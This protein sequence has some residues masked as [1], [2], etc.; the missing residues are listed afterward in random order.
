MNVRSAS[1]TLWL[2]ARRARAR[3]RGRRAG[4]RTL[5]SSRAAGGAGA[6]RRRAPP[7][8]SSGSRAC[9]IASRT[10]RWRSARATASPGTT[11]ASMMG[12]HWFQP[13]LL[14]DSVCDLERP[15]FLQYLMIEGQ[16]TLI[17]VG[18]V[19]DATQPTPTGSARKPSGTVT[20]PSSAASAAA[21]ST[22]RATTRR[23]LPNPLNDDTWEDICALWWAEPERREIVMLH[24]W[25]W[26]AHPDG[27]FVH[28]NRAIPFLRAGLRVPSRAELDTPEGR[29]ALDTLRLAHGDVTRR[30]EGAFLVADLGRF[31]AWSA[32]RVLRH[33]ERRGEEAVERM[34]AAEKLGDPRAVGRG[35]PRR[36]RRARGHAE[37]NRRRAR[38]RHPRG[39]RALPRLRSS[40]TSITRTIQPRQ[41]TSSAGVSAGCP[42]AQ[43]G[44]GADR[45]PTRAAGGRPTRRATGSRSGRRARSRR[46]SR[47]AASRNRARARETG[48]RRRGSER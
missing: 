46:G 27:P 40:C 12:E 9:S 14:R 25:N 17:G 29:A 20:A 24:T 23:A 48:R 7:R 16:R 32:R 33:G 35:R 19:C 34:R 2:A 5:R 22:T 26:I 4:A 42:P 47:T 36:R 10:S 1:T 18:Y 45:R 44:T 30:Y 15:A 3:A 8:S 43:G 21:S 28:E 31:D 39:D 13:D 38:S 37:R 11:T 41:C 6:R